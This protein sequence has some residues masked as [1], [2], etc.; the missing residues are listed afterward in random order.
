M[1]VSGELGAGGSGESAAERVQQALRHRERLALID[2]E[3]GGEPWAGRIRAATANDG[4]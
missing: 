1:V 2:P 4:R 3:L